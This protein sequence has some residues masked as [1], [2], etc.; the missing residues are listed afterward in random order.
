MRGMLGRIL[1]GVGYL[2]LLICAAA[3]QLLSL[4]RGGIEWRYAGQI[5]VAFIG[6]PPARSS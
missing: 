4:P 1:R 6:G 2:I 3:V 5:V